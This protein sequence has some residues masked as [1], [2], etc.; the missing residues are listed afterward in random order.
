MGRFFK[1]QIILLLLSAIFF[2]GCSSKTLNPQDFS[3][4]YNKSDILFFSS[5]E[6]DAYGRPNFQDPLLFRP[7]QAGVLYYIV[8][9]KDDLAVSFFMVKTL[10]AEGNY[11]DTMKIIYEDTAIGFKSGLDLTKSSLNSNNSGGSAQS[12]LVYLGITL[13][14]PII[15][16]VG[17]FMYGIVHSSAELGSQVNESLFIDYKE[18]LVLYTDL[19]YDEKSRLLSL[20]EYNNLKKKVKYKHYKYKEASLDPCLIEYKENEKKSRFIEKSSC[21]SLKKEVL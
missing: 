20:H 2:L 11:E 18:N 17:G 4:H 14:A 3:S 10:K 15:G 1:V 8:Q 13:G 5:L 12:Q 19:E 6:Y 21:S 9:Y 7:T 16:A